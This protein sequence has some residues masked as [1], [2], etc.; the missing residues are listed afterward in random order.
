M[1]ERE[2]PPR[3]S[4]PLLPEG[5]P[6]VITPAPSSHSSV[7]NRFRSGI[8]LPTGGRVLL[9]L[10]GLLLSAGFGVSA[11]LSPDPR[12]FGTHQQ[13]GLPPCSL[14]LLTGTP[15]P[16][17]GGTTA[18]AHFV[19]G[20]WPSAMRANAAAFA[21][22]AS[23]AVMIPWCWASAA[24]GRLVGVTNVERTLLAFVIVMTVLFALQWGVHLVN[25]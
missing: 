23:C 16:S 24:C 3:A 1:T 17:C 6:S 25:S 4:D 20:H 12:G 15:C 22:A 8:P 11:W 10:G 2:S 18:F 19:R 9:V 21:L 5:R 13:F 14:L 7:F